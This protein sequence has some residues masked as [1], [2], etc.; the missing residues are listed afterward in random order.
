MTTGYSNNSNSNNPFVKCWRNN[1]M[2]LKLLLLGELVLRNCGVSMHKYTPKKSKR[3][4]MKHKKNC[5][6]TCYF[7]VCYF[8]NC[9]ALRE[10]L[11][12][13]YRWYVCNS[14]Y[15]LP[16]D[17][18]FH[19]FILQYMHCFLRKK[20]MEYSTYYSIMPENYSTWNAVSVYN[21]SPNA[22]KPYFFFFNGLWL[23]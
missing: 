19:G 18:M 13:Y 17:C 15:V 12:E 3:N 1:F 5:I 14:I 22:N 8:S 21:C 23:Y 11:L 10:R 2:Y 7:F 6:R 20:Y 9:V 4:K 16:F